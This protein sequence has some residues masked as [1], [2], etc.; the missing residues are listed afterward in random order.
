MSDQLQDLLHIACIREKLK[1]LAV[2][3]GA[4]VSSAA[5]TVVHVVLWRL[6]GFQVGA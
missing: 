1:I 3:G 4:A 5:Q 6:E 2:V